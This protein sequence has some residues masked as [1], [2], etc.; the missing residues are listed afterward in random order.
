[1]SEPQS[2]DVKVRAP[3]KVLLVDDNVDGAETIVMLFRA[4]GYDVCAVHDGISGLEAARSFR[5]DVA[6]LDIGL[7]RMNGYD[8]ARA[9]KEEF[10]DKAPVLAAITGYG[11]TED[12]NRAADAGFRHYLVKPVS[13]DEILN[14][15][16]AL[17]CVSECSN[18]DNNSA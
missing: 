18:L 13:P 7:P 8:L 3:L 6:F 16:S 17:Q 1:M 14:I 4:W 2:V 9:I 12:R 5:P 11:Q 10:G 15:A